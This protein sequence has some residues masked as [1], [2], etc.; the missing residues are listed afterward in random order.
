MRYAFIIGLIGAVLIVAC[1]RKA[2]SRNQT[3]NRE[4]NVDFLF[5]YEGCRVHRFYDY[6]HYLYFTNCKGQTHWTES[7]GKN[8]RRN[9]SVNGGAK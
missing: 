1:E 3:A 6:G 7:C 4:F 2:L 8:C 9:V 5:E